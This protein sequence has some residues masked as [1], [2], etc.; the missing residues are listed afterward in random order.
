MAGCPRPFESVALLSPDEPEN[1]PEVE[2][3]VYDG[4]KVD[5]KLVFPQSMNM[6][7]TPPI[8][9]IRMSGSGLT[10]SQITSR[11]WSSDTELMVSKTV[12]LGFVSTVKIDY[13]A[14]VGAFKTAAGVDLLAF[15]TPSVE[16]VDDQ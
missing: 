13:M 8:S 3:A 14:L 16:L 1:T 7:F 10:L 15:E 12:Q 9:D 5:L 11:S 2:D 6:S 4:F